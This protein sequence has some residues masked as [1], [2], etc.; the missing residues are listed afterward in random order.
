MILQVDKS[1][2]EAEILAPSLQASHH[3][4]LSP[5]DPSSHQVWSRDL[6]EIVLPL[7]EGE[8]GIEALHVW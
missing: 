6:G 1:P 5:R 8:N 4:F 7:F 3:D 2:T